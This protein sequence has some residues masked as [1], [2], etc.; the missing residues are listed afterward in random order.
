MR[1]SVVLP[2]SI[3]VD[4]NDA[5]RD[6]LRP[7][8]D[9]YFSYPRNVDPETKTKIF[10]DVDNTRKFG[11]IF[12]RSTTQFDSL[13]CYPFGKAASVVVDRDLMSIGTHNAFPLLSHVVQAGII[14]K[15]ARARSR[16]PRWREGEFHQSRWAN[17]TGRVEAAGGRNI[18]FSGACFC[19]QASAWSTHPID[20]TKVWKRMSS[21]HATDVLLR[22]EARTIFSDYINNSKKLNSATW[23]PA[24]SDVNLTNT[25]IYSTET[26]ASDWLIYDSS[27]FGTFVEVYG[28]SQ[29]MNAWRMTAVGLPR[30]IQ[31]RT[32]VAANV[33][34]CEI[35]GL[36]LQEAS[37][38]YDLN[39][40]W[41]G[42]ALTKEAWL[43]KVAAL[44][45]AEIEI[46]EQ[47]TRVKRARRTASRTRRQ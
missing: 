15:W 38:V 23:I 39:A 28:T 31:A 36:T 46:A 44:P 24:G 33:E 27:L 34:L 25:I 26:A 14:R 20:R 10:G 35:L 32:S 3:F 40:S 47:Q 30:S 16:S 2:D 6:S 18:V 12:G 4:T 19:D 7:S 17:R 5:V 41:L 13:V 29:H 45:V 9:F 42:L 22:G 43:E 37:V 11:I 1:F 21:L 8:V